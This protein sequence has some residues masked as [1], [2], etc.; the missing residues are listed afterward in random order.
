MRDREPP[1]YFY[2]SKSYGN[3]PFLDSVGPELLAK[4][5]WSDGNRIITQNLERSRVL[6]NMFGSPMACS[7]SATLQRSEL[8]RCSSIS[9]KPRISYLCIFMLFHGRQKIWRNIHQTTAAAVSTLLLLL[10]AP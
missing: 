2:A 8:I 6:Y 5:L 9:S 1:A 7:E 10:C 3:I 4:R